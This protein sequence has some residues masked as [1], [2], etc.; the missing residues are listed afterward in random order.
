MIMLGISQ[1]APWGVVG[2]VVKVSLGLGLALGAAP[3]CTALDDASSGAD[4]GDTAAAITADPGE[5][6]DV[7][8]CASGPMRC[9][10]HVRTSAATGQIQAH[11]ANP[12]GYGAPDLQEAY[13]I[14][15]TRTA[16]AHPTVA[17]VNAYGYT[18]LESDLAKYRSTYSL[19]ACTVA[20]GCLQIV[21]QQG[22]ASPLPANPP[23]SDDWTIEA[24]LDT[25]MVSAACPTCNILVVEAEDS[26]ADNLFTAEDAAAMLKPTAISNSWG[27]PEQGDI[28]G[29]E[30]H[31]NHPKIA[32]FT[33]AGDQGY[34]DQ[35]STTAGPDYPGT[36]AYVIAV[37][38]TNLVRDTSA[39]GWSE[40]AWSV[41]GLR[42]K[43]AGGSAC[44]T[45]IPKPSYQSDSPCA[46][47]AT[48]D[49]SAVGDPA[50]GVAIYNAGNNGWIQAGGTS[51]ASPFIAAIFAATG[52]GAQTSGAFIAANAA[53]LN[54]VVSGNNGT[55]SDAKLCNAGPGWDGPTGYGT[56]DAAKLMAAASSSGGG[57]GGCSTSGS[58]TGGTG[59]GASLILGLALL[60]RRRR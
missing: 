51:A 17:V 44:S 24:A 19:P 50:T 45:S 14:D 29:A 58:G 39:R 26:G 21:N 11:T 54:D 6:S 59:L 7:A 34:N 30:S 60:R 56:P 36:S 10:A 31:F 46:F 42:T 49:I 18:A 23:A 2:L 28:A 32:T 20:N 33:A 35:F 15:P 1:R 48:T 55:C 57:G 22:Q 38:A 8:V 53:K 27:G 47:K 16:S 9:L 52:N 40:T 5:L 3:A 37:G 43:S 13:N 41:T 25:D 12:I 4:T